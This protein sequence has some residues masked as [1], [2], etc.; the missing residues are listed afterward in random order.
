MDWNTVLGHM[1]FIQ[2][3]HYRKAMKKCNQKK[4]QNVT[5]LHIQLNKP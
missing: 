5:S 1:Y 2:F 3:I 4:T